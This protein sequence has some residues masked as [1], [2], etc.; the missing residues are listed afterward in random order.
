MSYTCPAV[1][2]PDGLKLERVVGFY[3]GGTL[4]QTYDPLTTDSLFFGA[5]LSGTVTEPDRTIWIKH[6][7]M[8]MVTGLTGTETQRT[9][10]GE[11]SRDDS[12]R[13]TSGTLVRTT[14]L[15]SLDQINNLVM[16][17]PRVDFPFPQSGTI[18]SHVEVSATTPNGT[19]A[20]NR[21]GSRDVT[22]TFNGTRTAAV[23]IGTT[24]CSLDL[25]TRKVS[26]P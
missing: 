12:A 24:A 6:A 14:H 13:V 9:F 15:Q 7:P 5:W 26:C 19:D 17:L 16:K 3:S 1:T 8:M 2:T 4:Q 18:T 20:T 11:A 21:S 22:I 25:V 10:R 23:T